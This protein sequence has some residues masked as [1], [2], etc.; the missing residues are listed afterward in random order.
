MTAADAGGGTVRTQLSLIPAIVPDKVLRVR[1]AQSVPALPSDVE[2]LL[3]E[4]A[5]RLPAQSLPTVHEGCVEIPVLHGTALERDLSALG[6]TAHRAPHDDQAP[7]R[8]HEWRFWRL[9][10]TAAVAP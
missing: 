6:F 8:G 2:R 3:V 4:L 10:F 1:S 5:P 9:D 7:P